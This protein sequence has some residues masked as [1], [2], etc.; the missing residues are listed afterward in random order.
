MKTRIAALRQAS[1]P[2][3]KNSLRGVATTARQATA[4]RRP[5]PDFLIVGAQKAGTTSLHA[6]LGAHPEVSPSTVKEVHYFDLSYQRG[7]SWY[8]AHFKPLRAGQKLAGESSPYYLYHPLVPARVAADLPRAKLIAVLRDP[9]DRAFSHH[10]HE[11]TLGFEQLSFED[12]LAGE[13]ER[14]AG[15]R[16]RLIA[17]P[18][19]NSFAHQH[20]SYLDRGRY[21]EQL[22]AWYASIAPERMLVLSAE[23]LFAEPA[24]T[25]ARAQRFLELEPHLPADLSPRNGRSYSPLPAALRSRLAQRFSAPNEALS[26]LLDRDLGWA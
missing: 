16:E 4:G 1:P 20:Y 24:A 3:L 25:L 12:A 6:Y 22:E 23:E 26:R 2:A 14:L 18:H 7:R 19:L 15:E 10:N 8:R 11:V 17:D 21:A 9:V 13:A 5:D